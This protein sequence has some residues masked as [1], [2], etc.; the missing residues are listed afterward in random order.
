LKGL[1]RS[2]NIVKSQTLVFSLKT[3]PEK[4]MNDCPIDMEDWIP[5]MGWEWEEYYE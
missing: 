1:Y 4:T 5:E 2:I 3:T